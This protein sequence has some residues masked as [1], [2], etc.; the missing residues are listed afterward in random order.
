[1]NVP[2][3]F[4]IETP[5]ANDLR[6]GDMVRRGKKLSAEQVPEIPEG[7]SFEELPSD[8]AP[9]GQPELPEG[10]QVSTYGQDEAGQTSYTGPVENWDSE[11]YPSGRIENPDGTFTYTFDESDG[12]TGSVT[13][14][15]PNPETKKRDVGRGEAAWRGLQASALRGWDDEWAAFWGA[16]GNKLG[17]ALGMNQTPESVGFWDIYEQLAERER[18]IKDAAWEQHPGYYAAGYIPGMFTG[19]RL[20]G[21]ATPLNRVDRAKRVAGVGAVEGGVSGAG[22]ADPLQDQ[23]DNWL[24]RVVGGATGATLGATLGPVVD[25][26]VG[27]PLETIARRAYDATVGRRSPN[28]GIRALDNRATP[29]AEAMRAEAARLEQ[30][31]VPPR[32]VDVIDDEGRS[33]VREAA[34]RAT[35]ARAEVAEAADAV[36]ADV[37]DRVAQQAQRISN[38]RRTA[39]ELATLAEEGRDVGVSNAMRPIRA[40]PVEMTDE[41]T[42]ILSTREG[43]AALRAAEGFMTDPADRASVRNI[44]TAVR[45]INQLDPRLPPAVRQQITRQIMGEARLTVDMV[46]KVARAISGRAKTIPGLQNVANQFSRTIRES[47]RGVEPRYDRAL[48]DYSAASRVVESAEGTGRFENTDFLR[49][50]PDQF[51]PNIR[52]ASDQPAAVPVTTPRDTTAR[53]NI[54]DN[55]WADDRSVYAEYT[56]ESGVNIPI[57]LYRAEDGVAHVDVSWPNDPNIIGPAEVRKV[58]ADLQEAFPDIK[59]FSGERIS[60]ARAQALREKGFEYG[61]EVPEDAVMQTV[62]AMTPEQLARTT[63]TRQTISEQDALRARARDTVV[64]RAREGYGQGAL[65]VARQVASGPAQRE[66]NAALLGGRQAREL[67]EGMRGEVARYANTRAIDPRAGN[68]PLVRGND[69]IVDGFADAVANIGSGGKW[70]VI[71]AASRWLRQGGIRD[72]DAE[73]LAR[74]A[75]SEDPAR[76]EAA[77]SYLES[78]GMARARAQRFVGTMAGAL[79]GRASGKV[80]VRQQPESVPFEPE[81]LPQTPPNSARAILRQDGRPEQ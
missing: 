25:L 68:Q 15:G 5:P 63:P 79:A 7:F 74:D 53:L 16:T 26:A 45:A 77:I 80:D 35:P 67:E 23:E 64:D 47:A 71:R 58:M 36:Y 72:V 56:T 22:N 40:V 6:P 70:G 54:R 33:V 3:G 17:T 49:T 65:P 62:P 14:E 1:M 48:E 75:V 59:A 32:L 51:L 2:S 27:Q 81:T 61:D 46:D 52:E 20:G 13:Y 43:Q 66:R 38:E 44:M 28:A 60:G 24:N 8:S 21:P 11:G 69:A 19:Y 29:S 9:A 73:R 12:L 76:L 4:L 37:P 78:R 41:V 42:S 31:G 50:P 39:R 55:N 18:A 34:S 30:A 57:A 10:F